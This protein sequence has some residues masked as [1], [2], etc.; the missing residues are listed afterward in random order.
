VGKLFGRIK[1]PLTQ[2]KSL[3]GSITCFIMSFF[4]AYFVSGQLRPSI[5][6]A[7]GA[8]VAEAI[9]TKDLDNIILPV[10]AGFIATL[11]L[12]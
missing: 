7:F 10:V 4:S 9:P 8:T 11:V 2:G 5:I 12:A 6:I 3:E 1:L